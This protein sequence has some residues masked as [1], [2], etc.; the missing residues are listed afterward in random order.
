VLH[1]NS[2]FRLPTSSAPQKKRKNRTDRKPI[3]RS[4]FGPGQ[5]PDRAKSEPTEN[6]RFGFGLTSKP[7]GPTEKKRNVLNRE[8]NAVYFNLMSLK[9]AYIC[10]QISANTFTQIKL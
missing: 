9:Y 5:K 2:I 7:T 3:G 6:L 10:S 4:G 1:R 8:H